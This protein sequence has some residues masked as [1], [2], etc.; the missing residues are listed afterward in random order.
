MA[1]VHLKIVWIKAAVCVCVFFK[2]TK[3]LIITLGKRWR[4]DFFLSKSLMIQ[5]LFNDAHSSATSELF[6]WCL[7]CYEGCELMCEVEED[8]LVY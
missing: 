4:K 1:N 6:H 3:Q 8:G 5:L 2:K 7:S